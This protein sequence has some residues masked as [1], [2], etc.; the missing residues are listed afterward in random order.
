MDELRRIL[1]RGN[2]FIPELKTCWGTFYNKAQFYVVF[3]KVMKPPL[4][5]K[6]KHSIAMMKALPDIFPSPVA[7]P[8]KLGH[9]SEAML[10]ILESAEDPNIFLQERLLFSPVVIICETNCVLAIGTMP[11]VTFPKEDIY[12][13]VTYLMARYYAFHLTYPKCIATLLSVLQTEVLSYAIHDRDVTSSYKK[14]FIRLYLAYHKE[15]RIDVLQLAQDPF[16]MPP[17]RKAL[18]TGPGP[19]ASG[20]TPST[21]SAYT[22]VPRTEAPNTIPEG[23]CGGHITQTP[24]LLD[25]GMGEGGW[26]G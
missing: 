16:L 8:K 13:S 6:V 24:S 21:S 25:R 14:A 23:P 10:H 4:L 11:V 5:D 7:P 22:A 20:S 26:R 9:A 15:E 17:F 19:L 3:K 2:C 18:A 12:A 1:D